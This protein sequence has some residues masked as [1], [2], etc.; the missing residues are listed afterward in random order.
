MILA[1]TI[2]TA[3]QNITRQGCHRPKTARS[4]LTVVPNIGRE[5]PVISDLF[6][7]HNILPAHFLWR[8]ALS[9]QA[10]SPDLACLGGAER[11]DVQGCEFRAAN[12]FGH[13]FPH[14]LDRRSA[15]HHR[16]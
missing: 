6:P 10:E 5:F 8:R 7:N 13:A 1:N 15:L 11:L 4:L 2:A 12:L 16:R 9:L 3:S 14:C